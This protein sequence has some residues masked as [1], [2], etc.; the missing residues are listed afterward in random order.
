[1]HIFSE[2]ACQW[3]FLTSSGIAVLCFAKMVR[4]ENII[5]EIS[6]RHCKLAGV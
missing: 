2:Y 6:I 3:I 5:V 1:M 4:L